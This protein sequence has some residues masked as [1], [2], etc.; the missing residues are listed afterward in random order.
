[1]A[2]RLHRRA[3]ELFGEAMGVLRGDAYYGIGRIDFSED[4]CSSSTLCSLEK[5]GKITGSFGRG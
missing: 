5:V 1:M 2:L 4:T 3:E